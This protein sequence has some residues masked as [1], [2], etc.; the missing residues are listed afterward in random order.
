MLEFE[1]ECVYSE[2]ENQ[3]QFRGRVYKAI[4]I[5]NMAGCCLKCSLFTVCIRDSFRCSPNHR[6][7]KQD[8]YWKESFISK[9]TNLL[10]TVS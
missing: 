6:K 8:V 1:K 5:K 3:L 10:P 9:V 7:D 4:R 2:D